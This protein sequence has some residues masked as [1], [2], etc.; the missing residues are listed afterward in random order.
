MMMMMMMM[1]IAMII[2]MMMMQKIKQKGRY[3]KYVLIV[4]RIGSQLYT[5]KTHSI[6]SL[7]EE[8]PTGLTW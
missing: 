2:L 4:I 6:G 3:I 8:A 1:M 7:K 5:H